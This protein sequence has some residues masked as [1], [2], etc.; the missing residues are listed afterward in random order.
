MIFLKFEM[1]S[2]GYILYILSPAII[3]TALYFLLRNKSYKVKYIVGVCYC[4]AKKVRES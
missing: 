2:F 1:W 3:M 4:L